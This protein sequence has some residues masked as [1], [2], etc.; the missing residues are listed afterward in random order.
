MKCLKLLIQ[1]CLLYILPIVVTC[2]K[3]LTHDSLRH[4]SKFTTAE[5][6]AVNGT[7][8]KPL[9]VERVSGTP[10]N[11]KV[12]EFIVQHFLKL[13]WHVELDEFTDNTPFGEKSFANIIATKDIE[14]PSR[15]VLAAHYD[16]M[17]QADFEF[18]GATDSAV[19]CGILMNIAEMLD[20]ILSDSSFNY[21]QKDKT[22]QMIFFDGEEAFESWS[23]TDSIYGAKHLAHTWESTLVTHPTKVLSN[24]LDQME[25]LVLLDLLGTPN[26]Q[27]PNFY[28][29][30]SWLFYKLVGLEN[31][32]NN[33]SLLRTKSS[34]TGEELISM[35]NSDSFMTFRGNAIGDDHVPF[36]TRGVNI[37]HMIPYPFPDVWHNRNVSIFKLIHCIYIYNYISRIMLIVSMNL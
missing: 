3:E 21:K 4:L 17:Y 7:L 20:D 30:T 9:L 15:L 5:R 31:R 34:K 18:I 27:F 19:P 10:A 35:F 23:E 36:L 24:K 16:S 25:V 14:K 22:L 28:R 11:V 1:L 29:S 32:L 6:L 12:R 26:A 2:Y 33:Q 13:G 8:M 37:L